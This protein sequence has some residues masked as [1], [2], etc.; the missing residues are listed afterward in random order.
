MKGM[1]IDSHTLL[2]WLDG[3]ERLS[4]KARHILE[5]ESAEAGSLVVSAVTFW[6]LR[7]K[8]VRGR[9]TPRKPVP[10]WPEFIR[11]LPHMRIEEVRVGHWLQVAEMDWENRDPAD[12]IIAATALHL[13]V[14]V[15]TVDEKFHRVDSPVKAVW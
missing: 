7:L 10:T 13:G 14:T 5:N 15:V 12:R 1:V 4:A 2:W 11:R 3:D 9:L 8:E 6:E